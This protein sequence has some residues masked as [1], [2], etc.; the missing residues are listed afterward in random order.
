M[1]MDKVCIILLF[2]HAFISNEEVEMGE[3]EGG[4]RE[5]ALACLLLPLLF[6][7][8][9][10]LWFLPLPRMRKTTKE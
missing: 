1:F 9:A 10:E 5:R 3:T 6:W 4:E 2:I 7:K 8:D